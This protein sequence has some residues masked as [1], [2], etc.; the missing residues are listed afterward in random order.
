[1]FGLFDSDLKRVRRLRLEYEDIRQ[2]V[3]HKMNPYEQYCF[4]SAYRQPPEEIDEAI[5]TASENDLA[6]WRQL[7][8]EIKEGVREAWQEAC[9]MPG[10]A[11]EGSRAGVNGLALLSVFSSVKG[12][13]LAEAQTLKDDIDLF[14]A[15][16]DKVVAEKH[17]FSN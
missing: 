17:G 2:R 1:M 3:L 4:I 14:A 11:G 6:R 5:E 16:I 7:G 10:I 8:A 15:Q 13:R 12:Y 9:R